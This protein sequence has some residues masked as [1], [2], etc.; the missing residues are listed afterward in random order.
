MPKSKVLPLKAVFSLA[1]CLDLFAIAI[2]PLQA[3]AS[4]PSEIEYQVAQY[5]PPQNLG[6][7]S[8]TAGAGSRAICEDDQDRQQHKKDLVTALIP[9]LNRDNNWALTVE[10]NPNF[11]VYVPK[12]IARSARFTINAPDD[13]SQVYQTKI[14]IS[15]EAEI[16]SVKLPKDVAQLEI[17]KNYRWYFALICDPKNRRRDAYAQGWISRIEPSSINVSLT[18]QLQ[19]A[20]LRDRYKLY[21]ENGIWYEA[22]ASLVELRQEQPN[23]T[24]L[25]TEWKKFL[26]SAG[27]SELANFPITNLSSSRN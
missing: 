26:E 3:F 15:G 22:L 18:T 20:T 4:F 27:L 2:L 24:T 23:D 19:A 8:I 12:T 21:A 13:A 5:K 10:A 16:I 14:N 25:T 6:S 1:F 9:Q 7:P 11:F 17:G